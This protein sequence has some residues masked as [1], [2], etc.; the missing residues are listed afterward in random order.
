MP[1]VVEDIMKDPRFGFSVKVA[2]DPVEA[3]KAVHMT[4]P[5]AP[6]A[7]PAADGGAEVPPPAPAPP[8]VV[9]SAEQQVMLGQAHAERR[10]IAAAAAAAG[11]SEG[12]QLMGPKDWRKFITACVS[13]LK[14]VS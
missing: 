14:K 12:V 8:A 5:P 9:L 7:K 1:A 6:P 11:R 10:K 3:F 4:P 13:R 2:L